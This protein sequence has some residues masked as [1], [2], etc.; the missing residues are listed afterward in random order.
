MLDI[1][2]YYEQLVIDHLWLMQQNTQ[3][4]LS[5]TSLEDVACI[6][7]NKLP[8]CYVRNMTDKSANLT[9]R[10]HEDM[11]MAVAKAI[12]QAIVQ[13]SSRPHESR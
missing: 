5:R 9:E 10:D 1:C 8:T 4:P 11:R 6:A 2:N 12:E 13:V 7:L 3:A